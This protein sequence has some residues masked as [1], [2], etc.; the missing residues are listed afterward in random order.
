[1]LALPVIETVDRVLDGNLGLSLIL[2]LS[3]SHQ[4]VL[5]RAEEAFYRRIV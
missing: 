4:F 1:M 3:V 5:Q 2:K